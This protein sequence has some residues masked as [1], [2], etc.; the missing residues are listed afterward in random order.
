[1]RLFI[2]IKLPKEVQEYIAEIQK[3]FVGKGE[4]TF[5]KESHLT[6]KFLGEVGP[7]V[8]KQIEQKLHI[9]KFQNFILTLS[10]TGFFPDEKNARVFWIGLQFSEQINELQNQIDKSLALLFKMEQNFVPNITIA[11]IKFVKDKIGFHKAVESIKI[12][13]IQIQVNSF[14]LVESKLGKE[15]PKYGVICEFFAN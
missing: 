9:I 5:V 7:A 12:K 13:P 8:L 2:A 14:C 10:G 4:L 15:G 6:L 3:K 1:M 11:R